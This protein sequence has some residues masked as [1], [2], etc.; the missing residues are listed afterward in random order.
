MAEIGGKR[1]S[2]GGVWGEFGGDLAATAEK[3]IFLT[4]EGYIIYIVLYIFCVSRRKIFDW[5]RG[6]I[7]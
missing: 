7:I 6:Y 5:E 3:F 1:G 2:L 4:G